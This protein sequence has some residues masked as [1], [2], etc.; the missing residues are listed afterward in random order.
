MSPT[1]KPVKDVMAF[2]S[3]G[4]AANALLYAAHSP[5]MLLLGLG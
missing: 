2:T 4:C 1:V 3:R 5:D